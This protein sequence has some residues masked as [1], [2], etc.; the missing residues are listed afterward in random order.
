MVKNWDIMLKCINEWIC[1]ELPT[2]I[3]ILLQCTLCIM[4]KKVLFDVAD[5]W[6]ASKKTV[7]RICTMCHDPFLLLTKASQMSRLKLQLNDP[8]MDTLWFF[9]CVKGS[10]TQR[11]S[12]LRNLQIQI[13]IWLRNIFIVVSKVFPEMTVVR[14]LWDIFG[15][16]IAHFDVMLER[17]LN[18]SVR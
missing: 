18:F 4:T 13:L 2:C 11:F 17:R 9:T 7:V 8:V 6:V 10:Q 12:S 15:H 14:Y 16:W 3:I 1:S 5:R